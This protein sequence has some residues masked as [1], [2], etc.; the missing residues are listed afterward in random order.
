M[1]TVSYSSKCSANFKQISRKSAKENANYGSFQSITGM[2]IL[3]VHQN[4]T[5]GGDD[6]PR[7]FHKSL[8]KKSASQTSIN[9]KPCGKSDGN[10][11]L[12]FGSC[13]YLRKVT[14]CSPMHMYRMFCLPLFFVPS[15]E[16]KLE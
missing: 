2:Q 3:E 6:S 13:I 7:G 10:M 12:M 1:I 4:A 15:V 11:A 14:I 16:R 5:A 9:G 8:Q